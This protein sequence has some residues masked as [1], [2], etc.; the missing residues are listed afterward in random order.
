M[1]LIKELYYD[2]R[3]NK[4]QEFQRNLLPPSIE[5]KGYWKYT[6]TS[7]RRGQTV[8]ANYEYVP[9]RLHGVTPQ[10]KLVFIVDIVGISNQSLRVRTGFIT[11]TIYMYPI[12]D[13]L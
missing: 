3:P 13:L 8:T 2:A 10:K 4:S 9:T 7:R 1:E 12:G 11:L 6:G 5:L